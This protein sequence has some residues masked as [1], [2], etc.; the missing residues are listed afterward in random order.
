MAETYRGYPVLRLHV[1]DP[2]PTEP[3]FKAIHV[4]PDLALY[5]L[6][7]NHPRNR[8][9][10]KPH[11]AKLA[12]DMVAGNYYFSPECIIF[13]TGGV[14][15]NGQNRLWAVIEADTPVWFMVTFGWPEDLILSIDK[16]RARTN[17]DGLHFIDTPNNAVIASAISIE[18][19]YRSVVGTT[20][21]WSG[22]R[23]PHEVVEA[24]EEN[25][26]Q[27][28]A[29]VTYGRR[30]YSTV[31]GLGPSIWTAA[32]YIIATDAGESRANQFMTE[33]AEQTGEPNS[34]TRRLI[35]RYLRR[36]ITDTASGDPREP[37]ENIIRAYN[38]WT[39]HKPVQFIKTTNPFTLSAVRRS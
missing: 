7:F 31:K 24:F 14:L 2:I 28:Q 30:A 13:S 37:L 9:P 38:A 33:I 39:M 3:G 15:Q 11:I 27:W 22:S 21:R 4:T 1:D 8:L 32:H 29:S 16:V 35:T 6:T 34:P 20:D 18:Y 12:R 36:N 19:K 25:P 5:L 17:A 26:E 10:S 23:T